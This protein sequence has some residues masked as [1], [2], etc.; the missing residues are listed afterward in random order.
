MEMNFSVDIAMKEW[1]S[2]IFLVAG[3]FSIFSAMLGIVRFPDPFCRS[4]ALGMGMVFGI[5]LILVGFWMGC[6]KLEVALKVTAAVVFQ[7]V[8]VPVA[9]HLL[10]RFWYQNLSAKSQK[11]GSSISSQR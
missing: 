7:A 4:H 2:P 5:T 11:G 8:T 9:S 10:A 1:L 3:A 6:E